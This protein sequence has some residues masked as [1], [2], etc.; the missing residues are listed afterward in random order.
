MSVFFSFHPLKPN[1]VPERVG[2]GWYNFY[3][4]RAPFWRH[5]SVHKVNLFV[6]L[7]PFL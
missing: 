1:V 3:F 4:Y 2:L 5:V 6:S 7:R